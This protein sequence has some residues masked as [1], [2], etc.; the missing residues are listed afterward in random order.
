MRTE[1]RWH[2]LEPLLHQLLALIDE[3]GATLA[4]VGAVSIYPNTLNVLLAGSIDKPER[5]VS[6]R[7]DHGTEVPPF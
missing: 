7:I 4:T 5:M 6:Y 2:E 3:P 1:I